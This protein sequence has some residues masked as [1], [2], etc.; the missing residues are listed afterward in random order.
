MSAAVVQPTRQDLRVSGMLIRRGR[1]GRG[2]K[3]VPPG[4]LPAPV[5]AGGRGRRRT[6]MG[7]NQCGVVL[8]EKGKEEGKGGGEHDTR[9]WRRHWAAA[10][11][12]RR[13]S[14]GGGTTAPSHPGERASQG[15][16]FSADM[17]S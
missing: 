5:R 13:G 10:V 12:L 17:V 14:A 2:G 9:L 1:G 16:C 3:M 11:G 8:V 15:N 7:S 6:T 4:G